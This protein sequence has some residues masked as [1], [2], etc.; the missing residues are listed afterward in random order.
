[1]ID[2]SYF[3]QVIGNLSLVASVFLQGDEVTDLGREEREGYALKEK[4][5]DIEIDVDLIPEHIRE[6]L[7]KATLEAMERTPKQQMNQSKNNH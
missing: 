1:M 2:S 7:A 3:V 4:A 6:A 5:N